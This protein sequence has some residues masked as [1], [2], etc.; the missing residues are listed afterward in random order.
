[1]KSE[2][3]IT[4]YRTLRNNMKGEMDMKKYTE[5]ELRSK[6]S[7]TANKKIEKVSQYGSLYFHIVLKDGFMFDDVKTQTTSAANLKELKE[8]TRA[9]NIVSDNKQEPIKRMIIFSDKIYITQPI[10]G[11]KN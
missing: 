3:I 11:G 8:V 4:F 9:S 7:K 6:L 1:M 10:K 5:Q 2:R